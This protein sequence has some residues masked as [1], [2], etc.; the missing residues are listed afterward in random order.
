MVVIDYLWEEMNKT[1]GNIPLKKRLLLLCSSLVLGFSLTS[2]SF[3]AVEEASQEKASGFSY[4]ATD[5]IFSSEA[6]LKDI[7]VMKNDSHLTVAYKLKDKEVVLE[8]EKYS[9]GE[10]ERYSGEA[11][12][13]GKDKLE[14]D[15]IAN[16]NGLSG[17][18]FDSK[19]NVNHAFAIDYKGEAV[20]KTSQIINTINASQDKMEISVKENKDVS[21]FTTSRDMTARITHKPSEMGGLGRTG[22]ND[23]TL[24]YTRYTN[25]PDGVKIYFDK[26]NATIE[27]L[28]PFGSFGIK[29]ADELYGSV[30]TTPFDAKQPIT[31][32]Y[33]RTTSTSS[34]KFIFYSAAAKEAKLGGL[35]VYSFETKEMILP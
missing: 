21:P 10:F 19:Q 15:I 3:A 31:D 30:Y 20:E 13:D 35:P 2:T 32:Y 18:V 22:Y 17:L 9:D 33:I 7:K 27:K 8:T 24:Y 1:G 26:L 28:G 5:N 4:N 25:D 6:I 16:K 14:T 11:V 29:N 34:K 23:G 12:I